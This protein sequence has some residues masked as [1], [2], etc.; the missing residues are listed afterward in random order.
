MEAPVPGTRARC[1]PPSADTC[2]S[3]GPAPQRPWPGAERG[4]L[5]SAE[6][7]TSQT[8]TASPGGDDGAVPSLLHLL[9]PPRLPAQLWP[10]SHKRPGAP[11]PGC[12]SCRVGW[13]PSLPLAAPQKAPQVLS[14]N[15]TVLKVLCSACTPGWVG[16]SPS[17]KSPSCRSLGP[18]V[19]PALGAP[20]PPTCP[21]LS[22]W[23]SDVP[24]CLPSVLWEPFQPGALPLGG[25]VCVR[26][27][28]S[29]GAPV[30]VRACARVCGRGPSVLSERCC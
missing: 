14:S 21:F 28:E 26:T 27:P 6:T 7:V 4:R 2:L 15:W 19:L 1:L 29:M 10:L 30:C 25:G 23:F 9:T 16:G 12:R 11:G 8:A 24:H 18:W 5:P 20:C 22:A 3:A 13:G 17:A